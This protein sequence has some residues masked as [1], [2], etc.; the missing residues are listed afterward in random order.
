MMASALYCDELPCVKRK[1][2]EKEVDKSDFMLKKWTDWIAIIKPKITKAEESEGWT[3][4]R[5]NWHTNS[6]V[7]NEFD[8]KKNGKK[9]GIYELQLKKGGK[10]C[11]VYIGSTCAEGGL[12]ARLLQY[13]RDGSH[14]V[15]F[16]QTA[17]SAGAT[18][19]ARAY[20]YDDCEIARLREDIILAKLDYLWNIRSNLT[21]RKQEAFA[22]ALHGITVYQ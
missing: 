10:P 13:V 9:H 5:E 3:K 11:V 21:P 12:H 20:P 14:K 1:F 22:K 4:K 6:A 7:L 8:G 2:R 15:R 18:I 16:I 19:E 17:L